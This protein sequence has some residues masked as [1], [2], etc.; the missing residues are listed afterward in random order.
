ME[1]FV[2]VANIDDLADGQMRM[3]KLGD[4]E[5]VLARI[6][7]D[8]YAADNHCPHM[9]GN[10]SAGTLSGKIITCPLHHS[11]FDITDGSVVRWTDWSGI[12]LSVAKLIK[13][14]HPL[15]T[16]RTRREN[17]MVLVAQKESQ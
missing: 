3:V 7:D 6:G 14:P 2:E 11:Q 12:P 1:D 8:F 10:L 15:T 4:K 16:Y 9:G 13:S 17:G 5:L